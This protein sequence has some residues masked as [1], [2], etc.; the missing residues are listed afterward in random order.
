MMV[1]EHAERFGLSQLHQLR[2]RVGRGSEG[3]TCI[4]VAPYHRGED[5]YRRLQAMRET[6][7]GFR[8]AEVDLDLRGPG[9]FLGTRQSGLP[10]FRVA[11]LIRDSRILL[12]ARRAVDRWLE[13]DPTLER[14]ES[15]AL[16]AVL[17]HRW[18]GRLGLAQTG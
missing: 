3:G 17:K 15:A 4:L 9:E 5:V 16:R 18:A 11:N 8:I 14:P 1:I 13:K 2:G 6:T 12:E 7:D 10:D